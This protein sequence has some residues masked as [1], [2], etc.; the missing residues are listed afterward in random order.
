MTIR[1]VERSGVRFVECAAPIAR[2][3]DALNLVS[4]CIERQ[5]HRLFIDSVFLPDAFFDLRSGVAGEFVQKMQNY[6][7]RLAAVFPSEAEY[8]ERFAEF[9]REAR[10][11]HG[12]RAF[13]NREDAEAWLCSE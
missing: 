1:V 13:T 4:A 9:L 10:H 12:F 5:V 7:I 8:G 2:V 6:H 3:D 11:G